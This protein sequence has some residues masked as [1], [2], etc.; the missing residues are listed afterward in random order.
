MR[1]PIYGPAIGTHLG[2]P[3]FSTIESEDGKFV[4]DRLAE[5]DRDGCPLQQLAKAELMVNPGLIYR[6][7]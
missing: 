3:I 6:P 1:I 4:F 5:C 2:K 7:A